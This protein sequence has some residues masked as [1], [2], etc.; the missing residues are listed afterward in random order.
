MT[1][2][3]KGDKSIS[4]FDLRKELI[5]RIMKLSKEHQEKTVEEAKRLGFFDET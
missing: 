3:K 5:E 2:E 1:Y 4:D